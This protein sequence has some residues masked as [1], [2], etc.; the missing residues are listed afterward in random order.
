MSRARK[1]PAVRI[2]LLMTGFLLIVATPLVGIIPGPGGI[3]VFAAGLVLVLQNSKWA[4]RRFARLKRRWPRFG[5][6]SDMALR[7]RSFRRR[8]QRARDAA[9]AKAEAEML[10]FPADP[11]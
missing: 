6:Y 2:A 5:H 10:G 9:I 11:R 1:S 8:Q 4:R 7:R 3:F